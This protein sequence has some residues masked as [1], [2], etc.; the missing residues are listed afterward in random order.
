MEHRKEELGF[1]ARFDGLDL[2]LSSIAEISGNRDVSVAARGLRVE[3]EDAD[4]PRGVGAEL[5]AVSALTV[6]RHE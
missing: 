6:G 1:E 5:R 2:S 3:P 4:A